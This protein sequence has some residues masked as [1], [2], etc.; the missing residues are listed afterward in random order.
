MTLNA[1]TISILDYGIGN[2]LSVQ[3]AL[4]AVG[5]SW[6]M[7]KTPEEVKLSDKLILPGVGAFMHCANTLEAAGL[8]EAIIE[9]ANSGKALLGICVGMQLLFDY[10]LEQGRCDGLG[11]I[12]GYIDKIPDQQD[13]GSARKIPHIGWSELF[14]DEECPLFH[15][16]S[17]IPAAYFVHSYM[18]IP[19]HSN[20]VIARCNYE[21][22]DIT[23]GVQ[24][25]NIFGLQ[26]HPEKS[27][28]AGLEILS[29]FDSRI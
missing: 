14:L 12:S 18:V 10:G 19:E 23:C 27:A 28:Q 9:H 13:D 20:H 25:E 1:K 11:L 22:A 26:F 17:H 21:G 3:R 7:V 29:N 5:A 24:K 2:L 15:N 16:F 6:T 4:D 8:N